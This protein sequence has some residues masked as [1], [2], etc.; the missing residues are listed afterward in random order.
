MSL[1]LLLAQAPLPATL[2]IGGGGGVVNAVPSVTI[3]T[4][5]SPYIYVFYAAFGV[6]F[7]FTPIMRHVALN[8][9]VIDRPDAK[10]KL[11]AIPIAYLGGV[12]IFLGWLA[13][14][15]ISQG[16]SVH[17]NGSGLAHLH[18][19]VPVVFSAAV[20]VALGLAD[21]LLKVSP[22]VKIAGQVVAAGLLLWGGIGTHA[23][24]PLL[25]PVLLR[26]RIYF[27]WDPAWLQPLIT[28]ASCG[29]TVALVVG[30]CNAT[31]LLDGM[32][33]LCG[34]VSG[35]IAAGFTFLA[36]HMATFGDPS[37]A[38]ADGLR[39]VL[40]L[41]LLGG[42][43]G[44]VL[45]N[46]HPASIFMGDTG[47]LFIGFSFATLMAMMAEN[48]P[49]WFLAALV[50]FALPALDTALAFARRYVNGRPLFS[51]D[52]Q[53]IHHQ[54]H[55]RGYSVKQ[56]VLISYAIAVGF[57]VLGAAIV[58]IRVR[59][60]VAVYMVIFGA[61]LVAAFKTGMVHETVAA[62]AAGRRGRLGTDGTI[63]PPG[64]VGVMEIETA[65]EPDRNGGGP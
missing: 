4:V 25:G 34:G 44:F 29:L 30:C 16:C 22:R 8:Y 59:Y 35:I 33:G 2:P 58:F 55:G 61:I 10:R 37:T 41:A 50:M 27:G 3:D 39:V 36:V 18:L 38:N 26:T 13:G 14:L 11:H 31:N 24:D 17:R 19:P 52:R 40:G 57:V 62:V 42:V 9:G 45:F 7:V 20:I 43:L 56:T 23:V 21:D 15:A 5:L 12:A 65:V 49:R 6:A 51:A 32:D 54:I 64:E 28:V 47:S 60:A 53:H 1:L 48:K 63:D 46:F